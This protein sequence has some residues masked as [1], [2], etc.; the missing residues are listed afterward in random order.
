MKRLII[1]LSLSLGIFSCEKN[2]QATAPTYN[3]IDFPPIPVADY[4]FVD[5]TL[6]ATYQS[7]LEDQGLLG[8]VTLYQGLA[9]ASFR[10]EAGN[11]EQVEEVSTEG[12]ALN[13]EDG[14]YVYNPGNDSG[15]D[16][17]S[18]VSWNI[19]GEGRIPDITHALNQKVPEIGNISLEDSIEL[20]QDLRLTIDNDSPFT[21][22]GKVDS[23]RMMIVGQK[24]SIE[25]RQSFKEPLIFTSSDD[26]S[27]L[28]KG[29]AYI[30]ISAFSVNTVTF[31][32]D[33]RI[34]FVNKGVF[35]R[36]VNFY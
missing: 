27:V 19:M 31:E 24:G 20:R 5:A 35:T 8:E 22:L 12:Q 3:K 9:N 14:K 2:Q 26:L 36:E 28:G 1:L 13:V 29:P 18:T 32:N 25:I 15:I 23:L 34:A 10:S 21:E 17:G 6:Q 4:P 11:L 7:T 30:Q 33:Y 16:Y